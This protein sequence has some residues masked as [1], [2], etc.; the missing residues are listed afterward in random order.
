MEAGAAR[1]ADSRVDELSKLAD[2]PSVESLQAVPAEFARIVEPLERRQGQSLNGP[3]LLLCLAAF[4]RDPSWFRSVVA[5]CLERGR[6][7]LGLLVHRVK[8]DR[9]PTRQLVD[10]LERATEPREP[11]P[12]FKCDVVDDDEAILHGG[13]WWC[14]EHRSEAA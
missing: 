9:P 7:P 12:C 14:R 1:A 10:V 4:E 11:G 3:G 13:Q 2:R 5:D 6:K 8:N